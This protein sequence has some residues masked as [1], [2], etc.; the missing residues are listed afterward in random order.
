MINIHQ[1]RSQREWTNDT[2]G[3][4]DDEDAYTTVLP[5]MQA[6]GRDL[7]QFRPRRATVMTALLQPG[8]PARHHHRHRRRAKRQ[9]RMTVEGEEP[10]MWTWAL[11]PAP[12]GP[13]ECRR[14]LS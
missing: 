14:F 4:R 9:L 13:P 1:I 10:A 3:S 12:Y 5:V 8:G 7:D 11:A 6:T 2:P